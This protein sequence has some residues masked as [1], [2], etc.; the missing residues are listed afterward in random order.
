MVQRM[1]GICEAKNSDRK[2]GHQR[3]W[4]N[5][6]TNP[7]TRKRESPTQRGK[8]LENQGRQEITRKEYRRLLT[9]FEM[10]GFM[11]QKSCGSWQRKNNEG[12]RRVA[13]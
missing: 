2:N 11:A 12:K 1:L 10:E 5:G 9:N 13:K 7:N 4:Q 8:E 3:I 6:E